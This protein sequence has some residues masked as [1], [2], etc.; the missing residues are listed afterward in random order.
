MPNPPHPTATE[1]E[2]LDAFADMA[3]LID[4]EGRI[5]AIN[6]AAARRLDTPRERLIGERVYDRFP[7]AVAAYRQQ[8]AARV[9]DTGR[10]IHYEDE[11]DGRITDNR[12]SPLFDRAGRVTR[13]AVFARDITAQ[14]ETE[15]AFGRLKADLEGR[16]AERTAQYEAANRRL[17]AAM[18]EASRLAEEARSANRAKSEFLANMSHEIRTPMNGVIGMLDLALDT[19]LTGPQLEYL[20]LAKS[21]AEALLYLLNDILD[22]S[23]IEAGKLT[24][25]ESEFDLPMVLKTALA[26]LEFGAREKNLR[27]TCRV[28]PDL[29]ERLV[30]DAY[31]LRQIVVNLVRNAIKFTETGEVAVAVDRADPAPA[32][33]PPDEE[34]P[35]VH[36]Q[37]GVRDTGI[38]IPEDKLEAIFDAFVQADGSIT[39]S[40]GGVGLG[41]HISKKLVEMMNGRIWGE[42]RLGEGSAFYVSLPVGLPPDPPCGDEAAGRPDPDPAPAP[43]PDHRVTILLAEDDPINQQVFSRFL[44]SHGYAVTLAEDGEAAV[45]AHRDGAFDLILMDLRMPGMDGLEAT[46][47]IRRRDRGIPIIALTAHAYRDDQKRCL[48]A[49]MN[50]YIAKPVDRADFFS[51]IEGFLPE[52]V[53]PPGEAV[54]PAVPPPSAEAPDGMPAETADKL[55][56]ALRSA[57]AAGDPARLAETAREI[58]QTA[59]GALTPAAMDDAFRLLLS[60]RTGD[61]DKS[62]P[63]AEALARHLELDR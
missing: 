31:R 28:A 53:Q 18:D 5:Q 17:K 59:Q 21:S 10:P 41:L 62:R 33:C 46:R 29:P 42:S 26:P 30:A 19:E 23:K 57:L 25:E 43:V 32:A 60:A 48:A 9:I 20:Q 24:I 51:V 14:K 15:R 12:I 63:L 1:Q 40:H 22:F 54:A 3:L 45:A 2:L 58:R 8:K 34:P 16:V 38:G 49:G 6:E 56:E 35:P 7:P 13:L 61:L 55:R 47:C 39:R 36:L 37:I 50:G 44:K 11:W 4:R 27:L 52:R